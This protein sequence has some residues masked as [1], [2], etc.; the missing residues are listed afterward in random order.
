MFPRHAT[1]VISL[2]A[3]TI[4]AGFTAVWLLTLSGA[5]GTDRAWIGAPVILMA[6]GAVGLAAALRPQRPPRAPEPT[7]PT[8]PVS[9]P[10]LRETDQAA[11]LPD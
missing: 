1:D 7:D 3:G 9:S 6:A 8:G 4:F 11:G 10:D 2:V 5:I